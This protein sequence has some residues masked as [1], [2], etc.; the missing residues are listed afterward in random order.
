MGLFII[1]ALIVSAIA[2]AIASVKNKF[3]VSTDMAGRIATELQKGDFTG[4]ETDAELAQSVGN[5]IDS[6]IKTTM[7]KDV[8][9]IPIH[10]AGGGGEGIPPEERII[11]EGIDVGNIAG[12]M[13]PLI[14]PRMP[15]LASPLSDETVMSK[16]KSIIGGT[17]GSVLTIETF[18]VIA[19]C[20]GLGQIE[21]IMAM[22]QDGIG[23][24]G[25]P[26]VTRE[27]LK[28]PLQK[29]VV[30]PFDQINNEKYEPFLPSATDIVRFRLREAID[31]TAYHKLLSRS[32]YQRSIRNMFWDSHWVLPP[33]QQVFEMYHRGLPMPRLFFDAKGNRHIIQETEPELRKEA[34]RNFLKIADYEEPWHDNLETLAYRLPSRTELRIMSQRTDLDEKLVEEALK[35]EGIRDD[36]LPAFIDSTMNYRLGTEYGRLATKARNLYIDGLLTIE[37]LEIKLE[38][39]HYSKR[40]REVTMNTAEL[41]RR[42]ASTNIQTR[43]QFYHFKRGRITSEELITQLI[44]MNYTKERAIELTALELSKIKGGDIIVPEETIPDIEEETEEPKT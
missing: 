27:L 43:T 12:D 44:G 1:L 15:T 40:E 35:A 28:I 24:T 29:S 39:A 17:F 3:G 34:L 5:A 13:M 4:A 6:M 2:G 42:D 31:E 38:E 36:W 14:E 37:Q 19:E 10:G 8:P 26:D 20:L 30:I 23:M 18:G 25:L 16:V 11:P 9:F 32:G 7:D 21:T 41:E 22:I 33:L